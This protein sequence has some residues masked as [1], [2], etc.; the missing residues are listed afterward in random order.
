MIFDDEKKFNE[1]L[2]IYFKINFQELTECLVFLNSG[3]V[4][5][6]TKYIPMN[7]FFL[8]IL[9]SVDKIL[10]KILPSV[11]CMGR[12]IVLIKN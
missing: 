3:G 5:S 11:F 10:V 4:T 8:K 12:K 9:N 1:N 7:N 2:G 6:K